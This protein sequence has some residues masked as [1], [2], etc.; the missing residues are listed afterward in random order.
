MPNIRDLVVHP[1]HQ[2]RGIGSRLLDMAIVAIRDDGIRMANVVFEP[3]LERFYRKSGFHI[4]AGGL[5]DFD[6]PNSARRVRIPTY[7]HRRIDLDADHTA[8]LD[9]H[10]EVNF[11]CESHW[12][13]QLPFS[14]YRDKWLATDQPESFLSSLRESMADPRTVAEI[15]IN[16]DASVIRSG[17]GIENYASQS[18]H[19]KA[20]FCTYRVEFEKVLS[21]PGE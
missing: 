10:C 6:P 7:P 8:L 20:G 16:G 9:F 14:D 2:H 18:M 19:R 1:D 13:R 4:V 11:D 12:M 21:L 17:T 5:I 3:G 15:W